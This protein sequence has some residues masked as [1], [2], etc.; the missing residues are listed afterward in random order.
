MLLFIS[1]YLLDRLV[2][3]KLELFPKVFVD[4]LQA[5]RQFGGIIPRRQESCHY[6]PPRS[7]T[8]VGFVH[9][10]VV[11]APEADQSMV[12][13][14]LVHCRQFT[15]QLNIGFCVYPGLILEHN[16]HAWIPLI[17]LLGSAKIFAILEFT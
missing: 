10:E 15:K 8:F 1:Y 13:K 5:P 14:P 6:L 2:S 4:N 12:Q 7:F 16:I 9:S 3:G 17:T 11:L